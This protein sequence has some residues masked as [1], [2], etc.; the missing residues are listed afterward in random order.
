[1]SHAIWAVLFFIAPLPILI[2]VGRI[3]LL[4][5]KR[6]ESS[7][8][9]VVPK[10]FAPKPEPTPGWLL[11]RFTL[12]ERTYLRQQATTAKA[13]FYIVAWCIFALAVSG[14]L[15]GGDQ[16]LQDWP[17]GSAQAIWFSYLSGT[18]MLVPL[19]VVLAMGTALTSG[20]GIASTGPV[21]MNRT[22]PLSFWLLFWGRVGTAL[23]TMLAGYATGIALS[24]LVLLALHGPVWRHI[25][26]STRM[27]LT[28]LQVN[29]LT[30][31]LRVSP[32]RR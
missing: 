7:E 26:E 17:P 6:R 12:P 32:A 29:H 9:P 11:R 23:A 3:R 10:P 31:L 21:A 22:R 13:G 20:F 30:R 19:G 15:P 5:R 16:N 14:L 18:L 25:L 28:P 24:L 2:V 4:L 1:M 8:E 27:S